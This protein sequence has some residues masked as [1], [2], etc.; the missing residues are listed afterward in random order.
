M[1]IEVFFNGG[2][3]VN[4][5]INGFTILTDQASV[6]GGEG[7][8]PEPFTLFLASLATCAGI[9]VKSFCDQRG[10]PS[11]EITLTQD[12][13]YDPRAKLIARVI[14][15]IK[16]PAGFPEKYDQALIHSASLC[17]VKR[18]LKDSI[19]MEVTVKRQ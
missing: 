19:E 1:A 11:D 15:D 14:L 8:A 5:R 9:Y 16:V 17:A 6:S 2:K 12:L 3:K 4:A 10:I 18:H 13:V 7:S